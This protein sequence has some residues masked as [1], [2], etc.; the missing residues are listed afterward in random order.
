MTPIR[1]ASLLVLIFAMAV[2]QSAAFSP[3]PNKA[4]QSATR[5]TALKA[6]FLSNLFGGNSAGNDPN[7]PTTVFEIPTKDVKVGALK[8][9]MQIHM[10]S[11]GNKPTKGTWL[12]KQN[13]GG[14]L[15]LYFKDGSGM[16]TVVVSEY[17]VKA[18]RYGAKPSLQYLLQESV[19]LHS[20]LDEL[21]KTAFEVDDIEEGKRLIQLRDEDGFEKARLTLPARAEEATLDTNE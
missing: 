21:E 17:M 1:T 8:F 18:E 15:D 19:L 7:V 16:C 6:D 14:G 20:V 3:L 11:V 9:L 2:C 10:V 12:P 4:G 13:D 5:P